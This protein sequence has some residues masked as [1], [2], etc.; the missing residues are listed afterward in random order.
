MLCTRR[1]L[2]SNYRAGLASE[3]LEGDGGEAEDLQRRTSFREAPRSPICVHARTITS[4]RRIHHGCVG[5]MTRVS[6]STVDAD[7]RRRM[8]S[9]VLAGGKHKEILIR[10]KI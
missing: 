4:R 2:C 5:M 7:P 3:V 8:P 6:A 9:M 10:C 1:D